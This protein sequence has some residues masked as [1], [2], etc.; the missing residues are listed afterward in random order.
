MGEVLSLFPELEVPSAPLRAAGRRE[1]NQQRVLSMIEKL[2]TAPVG[3]PIDV[4]P[5]DVAFIATVAVTSFNALR[6]IE[7]TMAQAY[8]RDQLKDWAENA[9]EYIDR[10]LSYP[11]TLQEED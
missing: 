10:L 9:A 2:K 7:Q 6:D 1:L 5:E 3:E 8:E 4:N 11:F